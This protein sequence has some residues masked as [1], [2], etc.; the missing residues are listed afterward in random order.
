VLVRL[1]RGQA[2]NTV[3]PF[4]S[5]GRN[6]AT[7]VAVSDLRLLLLLRDDFV[8]LVLSHQDLAM[9]VL[10]DFADRLVHLTDLV[11]SLALYTVQQRL[12]RFLLEQADETTAPVEAGER[13]TPTEVPRKWTQQEIAVHLGT[14]RDVVGRVLRSLEDAGLLQISRGKITLLN[15]EELENRQG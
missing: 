10:Q 13:E 2:F 3:P 12:I 1:G 4:H 7:A 5:N 8:D 6:Q 15:R 11:E 14:V 9:A